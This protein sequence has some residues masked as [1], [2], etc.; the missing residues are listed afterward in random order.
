LRVPVV[1]G[2]DLSLSEETAMLNLVDAAYVLALML[3]A[4]PEDTAWR[5]TYETTA[6]AIAAKANESPLFAGDDGPAKTAALAVSVMWFESNFKP[7]AT[8]DCED[9]LP[10]GMCKVGARPRSFCLFQVHESNHKALGTTKERLLSDVGACV[11]AGFRL[12]KISFAMCSGKDWKTEDRLNQYAT[13]GGV[14]VRPSRD[15][16]AHRVRKG[17]WLFKNTPRPNK[18]TT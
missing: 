11:D 8:G 3:K 10:N 14:C 16:G 9:K 12:M 2:S 5:S 4:Q 1:Y 15:E 6:T 18:E 13:G 7:D 17:I